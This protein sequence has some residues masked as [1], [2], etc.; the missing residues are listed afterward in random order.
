MRR[1]VLIACLILFAAI[2]FIF[3][4]ACSEDVEIPE[5]PFSFTDLESALAA[6][7]AVRR[8]VLGSGDTVSPAIGRLKNLEE[9]VVI[10]ALRLPPE[11][12]GLKQLKLLDLQLFESDALIPAIGE[13][14]NLRTLTLHS[15]GQ[16]G[17]RARIQFSF[18]K[19]RRLRRLEIEDLPLQAVPA[20]V[21]K[22]E[23]L[24][25]LR[26]HKS[27]IQ[28]IPSGI[29][30]MRGLVVLDI[31]DARIQ[32][33]PP[34][35]AALPE[36]Q[37]ARFYNNKLEGFPNVL[38]EMSRLRG[39]TLSGNAIRSLPK[40]IGRLSALEHLSL[41]GCQLEN[42]PDSFRKL[43]RL[44]SLSLSSNGLKEWPPG[45]SEMSDL[46]WIDL[47]DNRLESID[48]GVFQLD[49]LRSLRLSNNRIE[50]L[51]PLPDT[52]WRPWPNLEKLYLSGN[53]IQEIPREYLE[54][55]KIDTIW[56]DSTKVP[57]SFRAS[58]PR[59]RQRR[60]RTD[61]DIRPL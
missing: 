30:N 15:S 55:R 56:I 59:H 31:S 61:E 40:S 10:G 18:Q 57:A 43:K 20:G 7:D 34:E 16:T 13:L 39:I 48:P 29:A 44:W 24:E 3:A 38:L 1:L 52:V 37:S 5:R 4:P 6:P 53:P 41:R 11:I 27:A 32:S 54:L 2:A 23:N 8:L 22:L 46:Q 33:I 14:E 19:L 42:F 28:E 49:Q 50:T 47:T 9:L 60:L 12:S 17:N 45:L 58:L 21:L 35:L 26:I 36:L 25:E 51:P